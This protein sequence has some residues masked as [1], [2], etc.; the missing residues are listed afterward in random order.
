MTLSDLQD[1]GRRT[2]GRVSAEL[3]AELEFTQLGLTAAH[4]TS[5]ICFLLAI[6][7]ALGVIAMFGFPVAVLS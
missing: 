4:K 1:Q 2:Q 7:P 3:A 5:E 6:H